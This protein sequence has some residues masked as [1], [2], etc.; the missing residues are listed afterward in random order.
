MKTVEMKHLDRLATWNEVRT[1]TSFPSQDGP[2]VL[3]GCDDLLNQAALHFGGLPGGLP[4]DMMWLILAA[5][6]ADSKSN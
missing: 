6:I 4:E 5:E 1:A 2:A 3:A